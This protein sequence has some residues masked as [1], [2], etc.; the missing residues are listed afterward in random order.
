[1]IGVNNMEL[2]G[3]FAEF[4]ALALIAGYLLVEEA[5]QN[6]WMRDFME[7]LR[8]SIDDLTDAIKGDKKK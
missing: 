3:K 4:G 1:M 6:K 8:T 2:L 7:K 5:K